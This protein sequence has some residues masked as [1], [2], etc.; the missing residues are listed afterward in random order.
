MTP[1]F[2]PLPPTW[3]SAIRSEP[4][5]RARPLDSSPAINRHADARTSRPRFVTCKGGAL[6]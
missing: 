5:R 3:S 6:L 1:Q 2:S 4:G